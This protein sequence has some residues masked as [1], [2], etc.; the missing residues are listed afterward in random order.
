MSYMAYVRGH[1]G[2]F[3]SWAKDGATG[4]SYAKSY[5]TSASPSAAIMVEL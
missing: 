3:D 2:N 1:P 4:W 5:P